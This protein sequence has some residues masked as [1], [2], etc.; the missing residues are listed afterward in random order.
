MVHNWIEDINKF[1]DVSNDWDK[2][3]IASDNYNPFLLS[4]FLITWWKYYS[5]GH[6]LAIFVLYEKGS[7]IGGIPLYIR[8]SSIRTGFANVLFY[9]GDVAANHTE[10]FF[11]SKKE[12][13]L[14][15]LT[16]ALAQRKD[17]D[18][19][20]LKNVR[21]GN[22][23]LSEHK[24][25]AFLNKFSIYEI[26]DHFDWSIDISMGK[27][28]YLAFVSKKLKRDLR[29]KR[30]FATKNYGEISL[31]QMKGTEEIERLF[32]LYVKFS[33]NAFASRDVKSNFKNSEYCGFFKEFLALMEEKGRLYA[34]A[35]LA[36]EKVLAISFA[37]R[38]GKG[39]KWILNAFDYEYRYVRPGY[40]LIEELIEKIE[41][42][43]E[44]EYNW[45]GHERFYKTQWCNKKTPLSQF[46]IIDKTLAGQRY[47]A[48]QLVERALKSN[49]TARNLIRS[50]RKV[51]PTV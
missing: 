7:I 32:D 33:I 28:E 27:G 26:Q 48:R 3:L 6:R 44:T 50:L 16:E 11:A 43:G 22:R 24:N 25:N 13:F 1:R 10:P 49:K 36:G 17:W 35:L 21:S 23:M 40:L 47:R 2:A 20:H 34:H 9:V 42:L 8:K 29:S 15:V 30:R 41:K 18:A 39:F 45:Y 4:D 12:S 19:L 37:Y 31:K 38:F 51:T 14:H 5:K 46:L